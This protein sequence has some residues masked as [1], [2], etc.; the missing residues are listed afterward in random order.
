M[1][2]TDILSADDI[3][4]ITAQCRAIIDKHR[5]RDLIREDDLN[6][7]LG[8]VVPRMGQAAI[9]HAIRA[10]GFGGSE[11]GVLVKN[12]LGVRGDH[13]QSAHDIIEGKLLRRVPDEETAVLQRGHDNEPRHAEFFWKKYRCKRDQDAFKKLSEATGLRVWMRYSPDEVVLVPSTEPNPALGGLRAERWLADYKAPSEVDESDK[14]SFQYVCQLHQGAMICAQHGIHLD[15]LVL[16][17]FDWKG[18][19]LKD[20]QIPYDPQLAQQILVAGDHYWEHVMRADVP[21]YV[22]RA[23]FADE[24]DLQEKFGA[25][26]QRLAQMLALQ[27]TL[28]VETKAMADE[29]KESLADQRMAGTRLSLGDLK[30]SSSVTVDNDKV[31]ELIPKEGFEDIYKRL[32]KKGASATYDADAM[33]AKLREL[34][35]DIKPF[36]EKKFDPD[37]AFEWLQDAGLDPEAFM[38]ESLRMTPTDELKVQAQD[39]VREVFPPLPKAADDSHSQS[40]KDADGSGEA[41]E[42]AHAHAAPAQTTSSTQQPTPP[43][44][45]DAGVGEAATDDRDGLEQPERT[46]PR[47]QFA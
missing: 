23:R 47:P 37:K 22:T 36:A 16:S 28:E 24:R 7:W 27:K 39:I 11:I 14:V 20:D 19:G 33:A 38:K 21:R 13:G 4:A 9:W 10:G 15:N 5:Q 3:R 44:A 29:I 17:Q 8:N 42:A 1:L 18:W 34:G 30:L 45:Q 46:A 35:V 41:A 6:A 40:A 31:A 25:M 43:A 2:N 26:G 12:H 32:R